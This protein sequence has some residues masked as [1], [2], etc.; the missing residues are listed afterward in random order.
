MKYIIT[1]SQYNNIIDEF[2]TSQFEPYE[3]GPYEWNPDSL[4]WVSNDKIIVR[5]DWPEYFWVI[6]DIWDSISLMFSLDYD[7]TQEVIHKWLK[8][9]HDIQR[10]TP[11]RASSL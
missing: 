9:H 7:E 4:V 5:I 1:E 10:L 6:A 2:I 3:E 8:K 11:E